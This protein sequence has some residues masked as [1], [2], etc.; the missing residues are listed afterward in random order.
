MVLLPVLVLVQV[1]LAT[2]TCR[3]G[4]THMMVLLPVLVQ[5]QPVTAIHHVEAIH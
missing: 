1:R 5:V 3:K 2:A 4:E